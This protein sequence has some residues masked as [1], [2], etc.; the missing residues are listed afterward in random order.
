MFFILV[1]QISAMLVCLPWK[2]R[3]V[4][5]VLQHTAYFFCSRAHQSRRLSLNGHC[6]IRD[7]ELPN[8]LSCQ[9]KWLPLA[10]TSEK[11][12]SSI[13]FVCP[14]WWKTTGT[15]WFFRRVFRVFRS[16]WAMKIRVAL[17]SEHRIT[18]LKFN[19]P[20]VVFV[21][22]DLRNEFQRWY[23]VRAC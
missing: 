6:K 7:G 10:I 22:V 13:I 5:T 8:S 19:F 20:I 9:G 17:K 15:P 16:G 12:L 2:R 1:Y 14:C 18:V 23:N 11:S 21:Y 3:L 4:E